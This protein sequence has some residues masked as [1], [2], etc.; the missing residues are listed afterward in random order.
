MI[1]LEGTLAPADGL[2][3]RFGGSQGARSP[4]GEGRP[5]RRLPDLPPSTPTPPRPQKPCGTVDE[6]LRP[7][8]SSVWK[9]VIRSSSRRPPRGRYQ[10]IGSMVGPKP[11]R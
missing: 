11:A 1:T 2:L 5:V 3:A 7:L 6:T 9:D 8:G 10:P 4:R